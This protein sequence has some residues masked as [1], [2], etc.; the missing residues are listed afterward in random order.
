MLRISASSLTSAPPARRFA[1]GSTGCLTAPRTARSA[2]CYYSGHGAQLPDYNAGEQIDHVDECLVP[3][4][5]HW[6][7]DSAITDDDFLRY[8]S[9]LP[10]SAK[11][12]AI[13]DCCH[14]GG[15]TRDGARKV[16]AITPPDDIRHRM[17]RWNKA[18]QMWEERDLRSLNPDFGGSREMRRKIHGVQTATRK[19]WALL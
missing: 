3:Y 17:L 1:N 6:T 15:L 19:N 9:A 7:Q 11:F 12:F 10:Y 16:R 14:S 13:F 8:Y 2:S 4:D 18:E 5:F